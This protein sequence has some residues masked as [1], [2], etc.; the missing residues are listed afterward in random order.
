MKRFN[1]LPKKGVAR[2]RRKESL[3]IKILEHPSV[4]A[5]DMW[6][7]RKKEEPQVPPD[8]R[9]NLPVPCILTGDAAR[10]RRILSF[11]RA[12]GR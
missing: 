3:G 4:P 11:A 5:E 10:V 8:L 7:I 6:V 12:I 2:S 9:G 1:R